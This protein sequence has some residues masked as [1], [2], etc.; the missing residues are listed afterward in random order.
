MHAWDCQCGTR[1]APSF[2]QCR[3]CGRPVTAGRPLFVSPRPPSAA[4]GATGQ[5]TPAPPA[6]RRAGAAPPGLPPPNRGDATGGTTYR[7][8]R[9]LVL[10]GVSLIALVEIGRNVLQN[11]RNPD[12]GADL[13]GRF[14][15]ELFFWLL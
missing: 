9:R 8:R 3:N 15:G 2:T 14:I 13:L 5:G 10:I 4:G 11:A 7:N 12:N 1:N 6:H